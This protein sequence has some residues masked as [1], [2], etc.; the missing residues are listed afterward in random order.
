M[1][2]YLVLGLVA[3]FAA[4]PALAAL[5][6]GDAARMT[7]ALHPQLAKRMVQ[8]DPK[9]KQSVLN[10]MGATKLVEY[11]RQG[12]GKDTPV[13]KRRSD[14]SILDIYQ[15]A[16]SAKV[17]ATDWVDYLHLARWNGKWVIVNVLWEND[18]PVA[19]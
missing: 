14:V 17:I 19:P 6:T 7:R 11:T 3:A 1:K 12:G 16:A 9:T 4:T 10:D 8:T 13:A 2:K 5:K 15:G 18:P